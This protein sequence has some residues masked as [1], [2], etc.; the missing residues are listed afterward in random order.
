MEAHLRDRTNDP[1]PPLSMTLI[2][3]RGPRSLWWDRLGKAREQQAWVALGHAAA[4]SVVPALRD[5]GAG[6]MCGWMVT[7]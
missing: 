7:S 2:L 3:P 1:T 4:L 6:P 5:L